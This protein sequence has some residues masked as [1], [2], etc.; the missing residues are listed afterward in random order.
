MTDDCTNFKRE[1]PTKI[2]LE[3]NEGFD[4]GS[5]Q[6]ASV[7]YMTFIADSNIQLPKKTDEV[8]FCPLGPKQVEVYKRLVLSEPV[9]NMVRKDEWCECGS[10]ERSVV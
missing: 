5:G 8:V 9:Q 2:L 10:R 7:S 1:I 6:D 3:K 4:Q